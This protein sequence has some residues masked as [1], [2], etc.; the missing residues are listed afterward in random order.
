MQRRLIEIQGVVQGIGFRPRVHALAHQLQLSGF[1]Q[2]RNGTVRIEVEGERVLLD[3][4]CD[5][6]TEHP[7]H[8]ARID[9]VSVCQC[10]LIG[11]REFVIRSS[12]VTDNGPVVVSPDLAVCA[13][14]VAELFDPRNRRYKYPFISCTNCGPR[15]TIITGGPYDRVRTTMAPFDLCWHCRTEYEN[16][17][18]RRFHAQ[19]I[20]CS[21]CGPSLALREATGQKCLV[22]D[23]IATFADALRQGRIGAIKGLG[24]YHLVCDATQE[25][26]VARLRSRKHRDE[27]PFAIMV[28]S[29][30]VVEEMCEVSSHERTA[31]TSS[32]A[33][34][35]LLKRRAGSKRTIAAS[36]APGNPYLGVMLPYTPLHHLLTSEM[37]STP[38][39]M[40]SGNRSDEPIAYEDDDAIERLAGIADLFLT[41]N[42]RIHVRCD[43][44]VS[45]IVNERERPI[46]RS[47]GSAP[48][49]VRLPLPCRHPTLAVGGQLKG[50]FA[51]GSGSQAFVSHH[52]G[53]LDH[54]EA[55]RAFERDIALYKN[56]FAIEPE[57]IA[58]DLH[59]DYIS[60]RYAVVQG[61]PTVPV[62]HHHAHVASCMAE[63]GLLEPVIGVA[64]DGA[65]LGSDG[66]IW[67]GEFLIADYR[68]YQRAAHLRCTGMPGGEAAAKEP[69]RMGV[70]HLL[71]A[72]AD[73]HR[74]D[75]LAPRDKVRAVVSMLDRNLNSPLT[76]SVGRLFDAVSA[77]AG[78]RLKSNYEGQAAME[79]EWKAMDVVDA[80]TYEW[81][82]SKSDET[83]ARSTHP[84]ATPTWV[85][86][87][88]P[89]IR[90][91]AMDVSR[92]VSSAVI[93]RRFHSTLVEMIVDTCGRLREATGLTKVVLSGGVFMN[94]LLTSESV[95]R[96]SAGGFSVY[97]HQ[98]VPAND[99]GLSLGQLAVAAQTLH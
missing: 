57:F 10:A 4:F 24:G 23:P 49:P 5:E 96:L 64:F 30:Q 34:V 65:G 75:S 44:S 59:P 15:L 92:G 11:E 73:V 68:G 29:A 53:D 18:D 42:R 79:L 7:P 2:N 87:T 63:H 90:N 37:S 45:R 26:A 55:Y 1:V 3:R 52:L 28:G 13:E 8:L 35:L 31:L 74:L 72:G 82:V 93:A 22:E 25:E 76:S 78:I 9:S 94:G 56:L 36:V 95:S 91:V 62:Q 60:T 84:H 85:I 86:D 6:L 47:R 71:D 58:H 41:H 88:R 17:A 98:L 81:E 54:L 99:G 21:A 77:L 61:L 12:D 38:L 39:V 19:T 80:A 48:A 16:P 43:D 83:G 40:T 69:W 32:A 33:P 46:R 66:T 89:L 20:A 14:C 97:T 70:S 67:G 27:K 51:L 50:T